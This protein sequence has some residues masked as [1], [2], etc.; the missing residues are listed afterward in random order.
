[1]G[2]FALKAVGL[3]A[4]KGALVRGV[5]WGTHTDSMLVIPQSERGVLL[6]SPLQGGS[7][8]VVEPNWKN[9]IYF[10]RSNL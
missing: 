5:E 7:Q 1:M 8:G 2:M 6:L 4:Q 3:T 10:S 9:V